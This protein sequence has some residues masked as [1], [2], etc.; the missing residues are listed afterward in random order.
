LPIGAHLAAAFGADEQ[1]LAFAREISDAIP[2]SPVPQ[3]KAAL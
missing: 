1:L 3:L 2:P